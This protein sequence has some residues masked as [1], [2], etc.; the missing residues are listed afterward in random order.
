MP[1]VHAPPARRP[2][3]RRTGLRRRPRPLRRPCHPG[4][5]GRRGT[6]FRRVRSRR[7]SFQRFAPSG[8]RAIRLVSPLRPGHDAHGLRPALGHRGGRLPRAR[9]LARPR[10]ARLRPHVRSQR[11]PSAGSPRAG[12]ARHRPRAGSRAHG[13]PPAALKL[14][15]RSPRRRAGRL[16]TDRSARRAR[17]R[18]RRARPS[19]PTPVGRRSTSS[20]RDR[21][22]SDTRH[23]PKWWDKSTHRRRRNWATLR[24]GTTSLPGRCL[25]PARSVPRGCSV[26]TS[27][28]LGQDHEPAR[29][30]P[31]GCSVR[32][33]R[34]PGWEHGP[35]R[36]G[37]RVCSA[38]VSRLTGRDSG[39]GWRE[40]RACPVRTK[41]LPGRDSGGAWWG[42][43]GCLVRTRRLPGRDRSP[44][45]RD[46]R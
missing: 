10:R 12:A 6:S 28:L 35:A 9:H 46:C 24:A 43:R 38:G 14:R 25:G 13:G 2:G 39:A 45:S 23:P 37:P 41:G 31:R 15:A 44:W 3:T 4:C 36:S 30:V 34:L 8:R 27:G 40:P 26:G 18:I 33:R 11:R 32:T 42:P 21:G 5:L 7:S 22:A 1:P 20:P 17:R 16:R 29:S 19:V